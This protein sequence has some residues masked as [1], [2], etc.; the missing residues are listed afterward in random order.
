MD[1]ITI[2]ASV[3]G[4]KITLTNT[5]TLASGT[6]QSFQIEFDFD[7]NWDGYGK[8]ALFW[9]EEDEVYLAQ[10]TDGLATIPHEA[11]ADS[12]KI[13]F[14]VY[15]TNGTLRLVTA[16]VAYNVA[17]GAYTDS[18]TESV[19]PTEDLLAQIETALAQIDETVEELRTLAQSTG[20]IAALEDYSATSTYALGD[21]VMY[22][23]T[24]YE[25]TTAITTAEAWNAD[26]WTARTISYVVAHLSNLS[27]FDTTPTSGSTNPVTSGGVYTSLSTVN[28][29]I[30]TLNSQVSTLNEYLEILEAISKNA[31]SWAQIQKLVRNGGI[32]NWLSV[33]DQLT[34]KW[35]NGSTDYDLPFDV[36]HFGN[37]VNEDGDTVPGMFL[38]SHYALDSI[39]FDSSE[40]IYYCESALPAGTY[41]F[42][43]GTDW[44]TYCV[45]GTSY[46]F[47]TTQTIPAGGQIY[48]GNGTN[49]Y[50]WAAP[51]NDPV[52]KWK[53]YTF[54]TTSSLTPLEGGL[55]VAE[56][57][58]GTSLGTL[59]TSNAY[60][61]SGIWN[62]QACSHGY[63]RWS[64]SGVR[65]YLNSTGISWWEP[66]HNHDRPPQQHTL[67]GFMGG[68]EDEFLSVV[69]PIKVTTSLNTVSDSAVGTSEDTYDTFFLA[70]KEQEYCNPNVAGVE[71]EAWDYWIDRLGTESPQ[72]DYTGGTNEN[73]IRY[74]YNATTTAQYVRLRSANRSNATTAWYVDATG[75]V[76]NTGSTNAFRVAPACVIC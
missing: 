67:R 74:A 16:K 5:P 17:D 55:A 51:D 13:K 75:L 66:S 4:E 14:G 56:G 28:S 32:E 57:T 3:I 70:S 72:A 71:G 68:F 35:N 69:Q 19:E 6:V 64:M 37:V 54:S 25:C 52:T 7:E 53:V 48:V 11:L 1:A 22:E 43:I 12:G 33:G 42:T 60:T 61:T 38:Q 59:A 45:S 20:G 44:G 73:H 10:V 9:N 76:S 40:A 29:S 27:T 49:L 31:L 23:G 2:S 39:Q 46:Y 15:G 21:V 24:L 65:Q 8:I 30:T 47:T 63:N 58:T 50:S 18:A 62:L 34:V 36:V 41:Y 26:H